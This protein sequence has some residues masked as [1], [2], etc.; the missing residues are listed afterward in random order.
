MAINNDEELVSVREFARRLAITQVAVRSAFKCGTIKKHKTSDKGIDMIDFTI[1]APKFISAS[2]NPSRYSPIMIKR[3]LELHPELAHLTKAEQQSKIRHKGKKRT[4]PGMDVDGVK[5]M[6]SIIV[7]DSRVENLRSKNKYE[8][9]L[10]RNR[11]GKR[12][13]IGSAIDTM[14]DSIDLSAS[15]ASREYWRAKKEKFAYEQEQGKHIE[16]ELVADDWEDIAT[17]I[18]VRLLELPDRVDAQITG[19]V[20]CECGNVRIDRDKV[21]ALLSEECRLILN[22]V[23]YD[24]EAKAKKYARQAKKSRH[25]IQEDE[26]LEEE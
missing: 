4:P 7:D 2:P 24:A 9:L 15:R 12:D 18:R 20:Q 19:L 17:M 1:E 23:A 26:E 6:N 3:R 8:K 5:E 13:E 14:H 16:T 21:N 22:G 25:A 11:K 10:P